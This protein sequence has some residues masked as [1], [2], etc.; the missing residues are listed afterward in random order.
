MNHK[1]NSVS[2]WVLS[3][4]T[5]E[6]TRG[7]YFSIQIH[8]ERRSVSCVQI[9]KDVACWYHCL[10]HPTTRLQKL[11]CSVV[12]SKVLPVL[13][14]AWGWR[15]RWTDGSARWVS[16]WIFGGAEPWHC[17]TSSCISCIPCSDNDCCF[18]P[19]FFVQVNLCDYMVADLPLTWWMCHISVA[20]STMA[21]VSLSF[22]ILAW[23]WHAK[24]CL[25][26]YRIPLCR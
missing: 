10:W 16:P 18:D 17:F 21:N 7:N 25:W 14:G 23:F 3:K 9:A 24:Q 13:S 1:C 22:V 20:M 26:V 6:K 8:L 11:G 12:H 19:S 15:R 4:E 5:A 2:W